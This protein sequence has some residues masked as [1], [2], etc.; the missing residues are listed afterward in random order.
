MLA[1]GEKDASAVKAALRYDPRP[2]LVAIHRVGGRDAG[3][4]VVFD[5]VQQSAEPLLPPVGLGIPCP[6]G[7]VFEPVFVVGVQ[8]AFDVTP[9]LHID[10]CAEFVAIDCVG[11]RD[12][13]VTVVF[14]VVQKPPE[15][16]LPLVSAGIPCP[17]RQVLKS[18][19]AI[20]VQ[21]ASGEEAALVPD[22][23]T[24]FVEE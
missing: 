20:G 3:V 9:A 11:L 5:V 1:L 23:I 12:A 22:P 7:Q 2:E 18:V 4:T 8:G 24:E 16:L 14:D 10:P 19:L 17:T 6:A 13:G 21:S 15:T